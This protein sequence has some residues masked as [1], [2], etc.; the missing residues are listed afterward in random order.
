MT[1]TRFGEAEGYD[2]YVGNGYLGHRVP[3]AGA[4]YAV[5]PEKTGWPLYTPRYDGA[6]VT[7]LYGSEPGTTEGREVLAAL[8]SWTPL[9]LRVGPETF[10]ADTPPGR[11]SDYRQT[12]FLGCGLVRT[13]LRWT[14]ADGRATDLVY[15][16]L[17]DR[18]DVHAGAVRLTL[19][20]RWTGTATVTGRLDGRGARRM[21][22]AADGTFRTHGTGVDGAVVQTLRPDAGPGLVR[23]LR[24]RAGRSYTVEK[25]VGVDTALTS[26]TPLASARADRK[27]VV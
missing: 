1:S 9:D 11:I 2:P 20:P 7:G 16:V 17:T 22:V 27:S 14:T 21:T 15:E 3:P 6:F 13:S 5:R 10:G 23:D 18:S 19:T 24:V 12:L 25:Y 4:G 8:P 26:R